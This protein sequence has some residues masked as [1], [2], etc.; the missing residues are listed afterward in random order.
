[1]SGLPFVILLPSH[2]IKG[3]GGTLGMVLFLPPEIEVGIELETKLGYI[4]SWRP[5]RTMTAC[6]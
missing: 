3:E 6:P 4:A 1:M 2:H 5:A